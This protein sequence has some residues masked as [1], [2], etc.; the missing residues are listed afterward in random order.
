[1]GS[2]MRRSAALRALGCAGILVAGIATDAAASLSASIG[3]FFDENAFPV[4]GQVFSQLVSPLIER[5]ALRGVDLPVS[6]T[7]PAFVYRFNFEGG[8]PERLEASLGP[9][10]AERV[11]T[12]GRGR[13]ELGF[14]Y[15]HANLDRWEGGSFAR[16]IRIE[17]TLSSRSARVSQR[18]AAS[19][20]DLQVDTFYFSAT[21]GL[22][23][24]WDVNL[25][26]PLVRTAVELRGTS[27]ATFRQVGLPPGRATDQPSLQAA[28]V[29]PGDTLLRTKYRFGGAWSW[30]AALLALRLPAGDAEDFQGS[31]DV[32]VA[33]TLVVS[34][35]VGL[36]DL[37]LNLGWDLNASDVSLSRA[38][39]AAG[40]SLR[41]LPWLTVLLDVLGSSG[42][43]PE[44]FAVPVSEFPQVFGLDELIVA[45]RPRSV[46]AEIPRSDLVNLNTGLKLALP[47][48]L[49]ASLG[50]I[51]PLTADGLRPR[52]I[53]A[54]TLE[55]GF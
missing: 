17:G 13:G 50:A 1:M 51:V 8:A 35:I 19:D 15:L 53:A 44:R 22:T 26:Q 23:E 6:A 52:V 30:M 24:R 46:V 14:A 40:V 48:H 27:T 28:S 4:Q 21:Y 49:V 42:V 32:R 16:S 31:G 10:F 39:Y 12:Q 25:L 43:A 18:F 36:H 47:G 2:P 55:L 33:P 29:G 5:I 20:F 34:K 45:H 11:E 37:H 38:T 54:G 3:R 9:V 7:S 41:A